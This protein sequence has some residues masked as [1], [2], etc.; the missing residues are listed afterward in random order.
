MKKRKK[1]KIKSRNKGILNTVYENFKNNQK[2]KEKKEIKF[3][4]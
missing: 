3:R 4:E 1:N 2:N